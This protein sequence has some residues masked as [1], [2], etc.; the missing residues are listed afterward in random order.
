MSET[1]RYGFNPSQYGSQMKGI[2]LVPDG[3]RVLDVGCADGY[4]ARE[5]VARGCT[6]HGIEFDRCAA[7]VAREHCVDVLVADVDTVEA[8]PWDDMR[9]DVILCMDILEHLKDPTRALRMLGEYLAPGAL[10]VVTLPNVANWWIR[11][12][13][14]R[15]KWQY[16]DVGILDRTHL[17]F[18]DLTGARSLLETAGYTIRTLDVT[19]GVGA[20]APYHYTIGAVLRRLGVAERVDYRLSRW[21]PRLFAYQFVFSATR[22]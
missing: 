19:P 21:F 11:F 17:R 10:V 7:E 6:V 1:R 8:L 12:R 5:L 22:Q 13:L 20:W 18:Y 2:T 16:D 3:S 14:L 9:F 4:I 15:G